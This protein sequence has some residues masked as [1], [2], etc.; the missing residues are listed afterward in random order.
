MSVAIH[1]EHP[2]DEESPDTDDTKVEEVEA[3]GLEGLVPDDGDGLLDEET[4]TPH[5]DA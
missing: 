4:H 1:D 3:V 2:R 5:D